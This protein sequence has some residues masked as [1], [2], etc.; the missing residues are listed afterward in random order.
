MKVRPTR[1]K[2]ARALHRAIDRV[3]RERRF[4]ASTS[5]RYVEEIEELIERQRNADAPIYVLDSG[6][7]ICGW[8]DIRAGRR[9]RSHVGTLGMGVIKSQR[10]KGY[11]MRLMRRALAHAFGRSGLLR[12]ELEV[13]C[14]NLPAIQLYRKCGFVVEGSKRQAIRIDDQLKDVALMARL[15]SS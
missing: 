14:D 7:S 6:V 15:T 1:L 9:A 12:V 8:I 3:A 5:A 10:G 2:D 4:L 13:F 11:G